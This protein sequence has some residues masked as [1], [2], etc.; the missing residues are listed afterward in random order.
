MKY[1]LFLLL[2]PGVIPAYSQM[3]TSALS[4]AFSGYAEPYYGYDLGNP[5]NGNRPGFVYSYNRHNEFNVNLAFL[6]GA[7]SARHFRGNLA[8]MAGTYANANLAAEPATLRNVFEANAGIGGKTR[9]GGEVWVDMGIFSSH[10]G[11]ES[12]I[13]KDCWTLTRSIAAENSPY[14][15][16]GAKI[17][18]S[19][20]NQKWFLSAYLL[21]GWQRI[22]REANDIPL[23][24]GWQIQFKPSQSVTLNSSAFFG[25]VRPGGVERSRFFYN[26][27]GIFQ[28]S[29]HFGLT[30]GLDTGWEQNQRGSKDANFWYSPQAVVRYTVNER[31]AVSARA[32]YYEDE[33]GVIIGSSMKATGFSLNFDRQI[34]RNA[35]WRIE[36]KLLTGKDDIFLNNDGNPTDVNVAL[37]TALAVWF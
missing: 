24:T 2:L 8:L 28:M 15:E 16:S 30:L 31:L 35:L 27:Y 13:G 14:Y 17:A 22:Q 21:N 18:Y 6:K 4:F 37:T 11:F 12:A 26:F 5:A 1:L 34:H 19:T 25:E 20:P 3:D 7:V 9:R 23:S 10:I 36:G 32:E 33:D 29:D